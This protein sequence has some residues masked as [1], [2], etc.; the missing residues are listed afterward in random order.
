MT[1]TLD[2]TRAC[3]YLDLERERRESRVEPKDFHSEISSPTECA[4]R[5]V[6]TGTRVRLQWRSLEEDAVAATI[7]AAMVRA[8]SPDALVA[9][10]GEPTAA[11]GRVQGT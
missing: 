7:T 2:P 11:H 3:W 5:H 8:E 6:E 4:Y 10:L 1:V 9:R